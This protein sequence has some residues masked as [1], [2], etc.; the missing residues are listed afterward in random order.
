MADATYMAGAVPA[1]LVRVSN[2]TLFQLAADYLGDPLLW[3]QIAKLNRFADPWIG[4]LTEVLI[5]VIKPASAVPD[6]ILW[7]MG[8]FEQAATQS[9]DGQVNGPRTFGFDFSPDFQGRA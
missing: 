4:G 9:T 8:G 6:G 3:T 7:L 5:P 2:T 1:R